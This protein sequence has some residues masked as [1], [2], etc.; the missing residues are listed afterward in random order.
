MSTVV[1][2]AWPG[3]SLPPPPAGLGEQTTV[4]HLWGACPWSET[5]SDYDRAHIS[6]YARLLYDESEGAT[7]DDLARM[8][9]HLNPCSNRPRV[10]RIVRSHLRRAHWIADTLFPML[11]W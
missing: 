6:T 2:L 3:A 9:F 11:G 10:Q 4:V 8:V 5:L 1:Q 7:E